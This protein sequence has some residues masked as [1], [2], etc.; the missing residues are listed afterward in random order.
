MATR[1]STPDRSDLTEYIL[2]I[3]DFGS[4]IVYS[5][6]KPDGSPGGW[7][8]D[9]QKPGSS[10][11]PYTVIN[12]QVASQPTGSLADSSDTWVL[13]YSLQSFGVSGTQV[14]RQSDRLRKLVSE[15]ERAVVLLG[16]DNWKILKVTCPTIGAVVRYKETAKATYAQYDQMLIWISKEKR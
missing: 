8:D 15:M 12:P 10:Y 1:N 7:N 11:I 16:E 3:A 5:Y 13:P 14:E 6:E 2:G 9:P 4:Q